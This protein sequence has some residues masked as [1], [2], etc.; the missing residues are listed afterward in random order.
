MRSRLW[1]R[2]TEHSALPRVARDAALSVGRKMDLPVGQYRGAWDVVSRKPR[3]MASELSAVAHRNIARRHS[4]HLR[5]DR[6][7]TRDLCYLLAGRG[8]ILRRPL[9]VRLL[10][11]DVQK[12][13][14]AR[15]HNVPATLAGSPIQ[16]RPHSFFAIG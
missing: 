2:A 15:R 10:I 9:S 11:P 16:G 3:R 1:V 8:P 7:P 4:R 12:I 14:I 6:G 13:G 5:R